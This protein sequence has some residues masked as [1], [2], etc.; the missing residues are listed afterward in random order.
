M[1]FCGLEGV[2]DSALVSRLVEERMV[3]VG[4]EARSVIRNSVEPHPTSSLGRSATRSISLLP[5]KK[6][7]FEESRSLRNHLLPSGVSSAC[8]RLT[9]GSVKGSDSED[10]PMSCGSPWGRGNVLPRSGPSM[11]SNTNIPIP[12]YQTTYCAH[13]IEWSCECSL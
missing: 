13:H 8:R 2:W 3:S 6:V 9:V 5:F 10:R 12:L 7:P 11:T 1:I 4:R